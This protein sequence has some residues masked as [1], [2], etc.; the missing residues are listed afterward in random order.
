MRINLLQNYINLIK[1]LDKKSSKNQALEYFDFYYAPLFG[2]EWNK[3]RLALLTGQKYIALI[4]N[5]SESSVE[6]IKQLKNLT[7]FNLFERIDQNLKKNDPKLV[8]EFKNLNISTELKGFIFDNGDTS[9][10]P[11]PSAD[12]FGLSCQKT[13]FL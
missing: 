5:Y 3:M 8:E 7:S 1:F 9:R 12:S 4:N 10:F 13:F 2:T 6:I 11:S